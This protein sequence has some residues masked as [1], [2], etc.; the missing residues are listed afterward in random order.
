M[1]RA[2]AKWPSPAK[3][4]GDPSTAEILLSDKQFMPP[5]AAPNVDAIAMNILTLGQSGLVH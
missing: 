4:P 5:V 3:A 1:R 2:A